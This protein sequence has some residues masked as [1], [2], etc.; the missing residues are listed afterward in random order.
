MSADK[1]PCIRVSQSTHYSIGNCVRFASTEGAIEQQQW[2]P[3]VRTTL[4]FQESN[5]AFLEPVEFASRI[6]CL[7]RPGGKTSILITSSLGIIH[8]VM[9]FRHRRKAL[10]F[11][12]IERLRR[13]SIYRLNLY[14]MYNVYTLTYLLMSRAREITYYIISL[15]Y[16]SKMGVTAD[17]IKQIITVRQK[18]FLVLTKQ[19]KETIKNIHLEGFRSK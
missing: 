5:C 8:F 18:R 11:Y 2:R 9:M 17:K 10:E 3:A 16:L 7:E 13:P 12:D 1:N 19:Y 4:L 14:I 6:W 15:F